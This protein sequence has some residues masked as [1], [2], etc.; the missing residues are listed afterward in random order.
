MHFVTSL[1]DY[2]IGW[3]QKSDNGFAW[4][5]AQP[6]LE[7]LL[8]MH[9]AVYMSVITL[10]LRAIP[11]IHEINALREVFWR[12]V[13]KFLFKSIIT[14]YSLQK[15]FI[16]CLDLYSL[17]TLFWQQQLSPWNLI[18]IFKLELILVKHEFSEVLICVL[19]DVW[20]TL[21]HII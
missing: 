20:S 9:A 10:I 11:A 16:E 7:P 14:L 13:G 5:S 12:R 18:T 2:Y 19:I 1:H 8:N 17:W 4:I 3:E 6:L 21:V 15:P